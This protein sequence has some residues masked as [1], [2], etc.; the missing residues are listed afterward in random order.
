MSD[1][2]VLR[3]LHV[4]VAYGQQVSTAEQCP[5]AQSV[6]AVGRVLGLTYF[7]NILFGV[8]SESILGTPGLQC[9]QPAQLH[10]TL[11]PLSTGLQSCDNVLLPQSQLVTERSGV[12]EH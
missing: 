10:G 2:T 11:A 1:H 6:W 12:P 9:F 3:H 4:T 5:E 7:L 8:T